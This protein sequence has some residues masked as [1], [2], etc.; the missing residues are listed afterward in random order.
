MVAVEG[1]WSSSFNFLVPLV[2]LLLHVGVAC[3]GP[4]DGPALWVGGTAVCPIA[5]MVRRVI[6]TRLWLLISYLV[7]P[8]TTGRKI[9][10]GIGTVGRATSGNIGMSYAGLMVPTSSSST[11]PTGM[12]GITAAASL[13][14]DPTVVTATT[15]RIPGPGNTGVKTVALPVV[16]DGLSTSPCSAPGKGVLGTR[17]TVRRTEVVMPT[18]L[19][20]PF[21]FSRMYGGVPLESNALWINGSVAGKIS[22]PLGVILLEVT[23]AVDTA[24]VPGEWVTDGVIP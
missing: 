17:G 23:T 15:Y 16:P 20:G 10:D 6:G 19:G 8:V 1:F 18:F 22:G 5:G 21:A 14:T 4:T 7:T 13:T 2:P 9:W 11:V 12:P 24:A 3:P